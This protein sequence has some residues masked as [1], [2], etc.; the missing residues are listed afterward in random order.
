MEESNTANI[1]LCMS[2]MT[3]P[4]KADGSNMIEEDLLKGNLVDYIRNTV[5]AEAIKERGSKLSDKDN[6]FDSDNCSEIE[7]FDDSSEKHN[8]DSN[9]EGLR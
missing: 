9:L 8:D 1:L 5:R 7:N 3:A 4:N 2:S 6:S